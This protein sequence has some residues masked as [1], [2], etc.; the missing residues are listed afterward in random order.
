MGDS[1]S[2]EI[3]LDSVIERLLEGESAYLEL[4]YRVVG[5]RG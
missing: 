5:E 4:S 3:D 1:S 2:I